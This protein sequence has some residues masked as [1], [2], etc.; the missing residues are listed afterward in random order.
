MKLE[1]ETVGPF[2][3]FTFTKTI[4]G[5]KA[6]SAL[7][8]F[9]LGDTLIDGG[10]ESA[11]PFLIE[12]MAEDPPRRILLTHQ[13]E[14]HIGGL[15]RLVQAWGRLPV[16]APREHLE[17]IRSGYTVPQYRIDHWGDTRAYP[18]LELIPY[19]AGDVYNAGGFDL[20][21]LDTPGHTPGHK[22]F[23]LRDGE[24]IFVISG[25]LYLAP[26]LPNAFFETSVPD[27]IASLDRLAALG[28][29]FTLMP[30]HGGPYSDGA[31]RV[32]QLR[33]WYVKERAAILKIHREQP[34]ADYNAIFQARH[35][36][37]NPMELLSRGELSRCALIRG[38]IDPVVELPAMPIVLDAKLYA[39][40]RKRIEQRGKG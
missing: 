7:N 38:V 26:R 1:Q 13:H 21:I 35:D 6:S 31:K 25:D 10:S 14:D 29:E 8:V 20:E 15:G 24:R 22:S 27:M 12:A 3:K 39:A 37:Y 33:D 17:I 23:A 40:S 32:R 30:S 2:S 11:A 34:A 19:D 18:D 5:Q 28:D 9:R 4:P 16:H 36:F